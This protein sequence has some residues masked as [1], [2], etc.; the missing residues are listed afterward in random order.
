MRF[1]RNGEL[2]NALLFIFPRNSFRTTKSAL[3][4]KWAGY[5]DNYWSARGVLNVFAP[6]TLGALE[7]CK[8]PI[9]P[10]VKRGLNFARRYPSNRFLNTK[11]ITFQLTGER[12]N[13]LRQT[14]VEAHWNVF[15]SHYS[16]RGGRPDQRAWPRSVRI[17]HVR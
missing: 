7:N 8:I 17:S 3:Y 2:D 13:N 9:T 16:I 10:W 11:L 12:Y 14:T 6:Y 1:A 4:Y 15:C 5:I